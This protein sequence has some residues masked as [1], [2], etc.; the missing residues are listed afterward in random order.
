MP[1]DPSNPV[2]RIK[3]IV[4]N[5]NARFVLTSPTYRSTFED[6]EKITVVVDASF[7]RERNVSSIPLVKVSPHSPASV[8]FTSASTGQPKGVVQVHDSVCNIGKAYGET[9]YVDHNSRVL[10]SARYMIRRQIR[11]TSSPQNM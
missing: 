6:A 7:T 1:L 2:D 5:V 9:L 10:Q 11:Y 4:G 3:A 8:L